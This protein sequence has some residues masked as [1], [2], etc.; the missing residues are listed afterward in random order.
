MPKETFRTMLAIWKAID[1]NKNKFQPKYKQMYLDVIWVILHENYAKKIL[2][3][4]MF[5][6]ECE[7][8]F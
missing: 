8:K 7:D 1:F 3:K 6:N 4:V 2:L 5:L